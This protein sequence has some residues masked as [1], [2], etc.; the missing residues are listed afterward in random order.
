MIC[1]ACLNDNF[2]CICNDV[3][4][5]SPVA[6]SFNRKRHRSN[7]NVQSATPNQDNSLPIVNGNSDNIFNFTKPGFK[8]SNIN[9]QHFL[10]KIDKIKANFTKLK[11][12]EKPHVVGFCETFLT[13]TNCQENSNE[14]NIDGYSCKIARKDRKNK[15]VVF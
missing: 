11:Q 8:I 1:N 2:N 13:S 12:E 3:S 14:L 6:K 4:L 15:K 7:I 9:I 5:S 10:P